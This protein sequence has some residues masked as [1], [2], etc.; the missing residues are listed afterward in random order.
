MYTP[1]EARSAFQN[2]TTKLSLSF[3]ALF[4]LLKILVFSFF[5]TKGPHA[6]GA[7]KKKKRFFFSSTPVG[8]IED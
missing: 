6:W 2:R 1:C 4:I 5:F 8:I 3:L 7:D